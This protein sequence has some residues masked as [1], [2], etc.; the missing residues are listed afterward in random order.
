V[1]TTSK[2]TRVTNSDIRALIEEV[3]LVPDD[4]NL[5]IELFGALS[6]LFNLTN[7]LPR[8]KETGVQVTLVAGARSLLFRTQVSAF[9]TIP[10]KVVARA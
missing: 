8:S 9:L 4:G 6:T 2:V 1:S 5:R 3:R 7:E 10:P